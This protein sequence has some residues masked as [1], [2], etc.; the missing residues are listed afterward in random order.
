MSK[1]QHAP[2]SFSSVAIACLGQSLDGRR[3]AVRQVASVTAEDEIKCQPV[4]IGK[5]DP[6]L[7]RRKAL[8]KLYHVVRIWFY[9]G[10]TAEF[11]LIHAKNLADEPEAQRDIVLEPVAR[12]GLP[13]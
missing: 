11:A 10:S 1:T 2:R 12:V 3:D 9:S 8:A 6:D 7:Y 4:G 13:N 5:S